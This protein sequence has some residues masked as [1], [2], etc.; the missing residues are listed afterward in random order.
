MSTVAESPSVCELCGETYV[1]IT[2]LRL[3]RQEG[4]KATITVTE[5]PHR[6]C[7]MIPDPSRLV[8]TAHADNLKQGMSLA[9]LRSAID[10]CD[11]VDGTVRVLVNLRSGIKR[12]TVEET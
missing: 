2:R 1:Q 12:I 6:P 7:P 3:I 9:E 8:V 11:M 10:E 5:Y 4:D